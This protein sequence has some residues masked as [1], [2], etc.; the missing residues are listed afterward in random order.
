MGLAK[1][2]AI[3]KAP[4]D[5]AGNPGSRPVDQTELRFQ[6]VD[7]FYSNSRILSEISQLTQNAEI[8]AI[9]YR[10]PQFRISVKVKVTLQHSRYTL[11]RPELTEILKAQALTDGRR[12]SMVKT[13]A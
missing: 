3:R 11:T 4:S 9:A 12:L 13:C 6:P 1:G 5:A 8:L 2:S 7:L 10:V